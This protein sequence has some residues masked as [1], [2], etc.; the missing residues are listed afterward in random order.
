MKDAHPLHNTHCVF[1]YLLLCVCYTEDKSSTTAAIVLAVL[2]VFALLTA[3]ALVSRLICNHF[4]RKRSRGYLNPPTRSSLVRTN[5]SRMDSAPDMQRLSSQGPPMPVAAEV[6]GQLGDVSEPRLDSLSSECYQPL[7]ASPRVPMSGSGEQVR[8]V[9]GR[10][11]HIYSTIES[12]EPHDGWIQEGSV[13]N[14]E[15][16]I[17]YTPTSEPV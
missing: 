5:L 10:E 1:F 4:R 3:V 11:M 15:A 2:L 17:I 12:Q 13:N 6:K 7:P 9:Q 16:E 8:H 14:R